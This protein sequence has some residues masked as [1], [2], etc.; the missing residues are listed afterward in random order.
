MPDSDT[1]KARDALLAKAAEAWRED[2]VL[3]NDDVSCFLDAYYQ[4]VAAEDLAPPSRLAAVA[5]AHAKL[6]YNRPQ[7]RALVQVREA[8][9]AYLDPLTSS[10][11]VVNIVTDDMPYLVDSVTTEL[12]RHQAEV[13]MI[14]HPLLR[15]R[16]DVTGALRAI[17]GVCGDDVD[18]AATGELVESWIH[19]ELAPSKDRIDPDQL[20][21]D[22]RHVLDDV[23]VANE[24]QQRMD[25]VARRLA[26]DLDA[27]GGP[28]AAEYGELL[29]WLADG[30]F[31]FLGYREYDLVPVEAGIG[32]RPVPG[33]GLG[34][35]RHRKPGQQSLN[36]LS[37]QIAA[38]AQDPAERLVLAKANSRSTVYRANYLDYVSVKRHDAAGKVT[39]ELRFL[40][41]YT[42]S[43]HT[44]PVASIPVLRGKLAYVLA[45]AGLTRDS[46][47]GKDLI[48]ILED[49]PREE[50]FEIS[51][52]ELTPIAFGV[53]RLSERKQTRLFLR[54]D[55]Y[56]RYMSCLVYLPR[57]RYTTKVRLRAQGILKAA[58]RGVT[59]DYS[60][61]V[62][63]S[64]L[65]RLH[66]V[67]RGE[68]GAP[69]P[70][71][72]AAALERRL[73][74]AVRSWDEDLVAEATRVLGEEQGRGLLETFAAAIPETYKADV[75]AT[76]AVED[77]TTMLKLRESG[78]EF[79]VRLVEGEERWTLVVYRL[80]TP[81]TL[82]DVLPQL[83]HMGLEVVDEH[84]YEFAGHSSTGS[85]WIY[86]FG[87]RPP[88]GLASV[89]VRPIFEDAVT[90]LW[91]GQT[92]DDGFNA[93]VLTAGLTWRE[94]TLLRAVAKYLR[95]GGMR[96]SED[97]VQRVLRSNAAIARLLVRLFES[98]FDPAKQDGAA[99]RCEAIAEEIRGMLD[100]VVS[101]DHDRILRAYL[102]M[103]DATLRTNYYKTSS[104][105]GVDGPPTLTLKL[106]PGNLPEL[107]S[108]RPKFEI[109]VYSPRLEAV[110]L[111]FGRV[112]R[113]GLRWSD[114]LEDFRTE[115][116]GLVKAQE[117]KNAVIVPSGAKG[118][119]VCKRLPDPG[120]REAYQAEVLACYKTFIASMLDVT[121]NIEGEAVIPPPEVVRR[122]GDDPYLVV[123]ADKGTATFSDTANEVAARY[124]FWLGDAFASG[125]SEGYDHKK[126]GI[127]ARGAWESVKVHFAALGLNPATDDFTMAG[128]GDMSGDVFGNG[129]LLSEHIK[130]VA[131][132]DHRHVFVDPDPDPAASF[133]ERQ[134][135]FDL[136]RSS[137]ADYDE[138]LISPGGGV[139]PRAVKS[140]PVSPQARTALGIEAGVTAL[141]PDALISAILAAPVDLLW[142]GGIGTYVKASHESHADVGDRSNDAVRVDATRLRCRVIG[143]GGNLGLTQAARIEYSLDGG[144]VNT[145]FIDNSAGVDTSDH[146]VNIKILLAD[147]IRAGEMPAAARHQLLNDMTD[148]VAS[149]VL[150]HNYGQN[151]ALAASRAQAP[152]LLHVHA[153]YLRKLVRDKRLDSELD[154]L[155]GER[156][157]A[158][159]RSAGTGLTTPEF[160]LLLAHTKIS[161]A[162]DVLA[163]GLPDDPYLRRVLEAYFPAPLRSA[164]ADR[165]QA[166]PLRREI[167]TT[168]VVNEMIDTS[169]TTFLFRLIEET[170]ASVPDLTRAWLVAREVFDMSAFWHQVEELEG[171]VGL[172]AQITLLLEGRK[173]TERA[174]RWLLHN[175]RPPFDLQAT[176]N[177]FADGV[178]TVRAGLPKLLTGRD[179]ATFEERRDSYLV[180]DVP[181]E[182]AERVAAMVPTYSAFDIVQVASVTG[183]SVEEA[184]EVYFDLADRLQ[185][186]RLRDRITALPREDR[187]S[188]MAR[189][190]LRDDLYAA[191][192]SLARDVLGASRSAIPR[193]PEEQLA[194]WAAQNESA[195]GMATQTLGE[196]WESERFTFTTLSVALRAIRTLVASSSL[197]QA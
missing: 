66:V 49:Y 93:L 142:N 144:L 92:E 193:N 102:A 28:D 86:E 134:R 26:D 146:E 43:A 140:V 163:S 111:R 15:D 81:I 75:T 116:L 170:G 103:I 84:P 196:I 158:E 18:P 74:A 169:G 89:T 195:V 159:R 71:V 59:V 197:P 129:V 135:M 166:H 22:L 1:D 172:A 156:E 56:G 109:F 83:Q 78:T 9:H 99:E 118:G 123:A 5:E 97:Y 112:A 50:L 87:L 90:A 101:L 147:A 79:A 54:R 82:S 40:G 128:V 77:L 137:W 67:I 139:W 108:P 105:G 126:M 70:Q 186:T 94:V 115:V 95:Q 164:F 11:L 127:T 149:L 155:P 148:D 42:H 130:L 145:D 191:L 32:L 120:D 173:L 188:T 183:R 114:R 20:A 55:R 10:G 176:V 63:D 73:A 60:A 6:G 161:A 165:M 65:A 68:K 8:G 33:S 157:I 106:D 131:A 25:E 174:V 14:V 117:V 16:R 119:F 132:F 194:A 35:L 58:L 76:Y 23:R 136:P 24:D 98:R 34:I 162:E 27:E 52:E 184:A 138:A 180:L 3:A 154:V 29:R 175:R 100:E 181:E 185:I 125:G 80:G 38:R 178:R 39:R 150:R 30:N 36:K 177:F 124:G 96:F 153:R 46:H 64:A 45:S 48:E 2:P 17:I 152:S 133:A 19:V 88:A 13:Q 160:A 37:S 189:A 91:Q 141:S 41:L 151:M 167:I 21:A 107:A 171:R 122:D 143:E 192:A 7:G 72:D 182:L 187:W 53:L 121:D 179:L 4:R 69:V 110:H 104:R 51:A 190:A 113:G 62:G 57:D 44:A 61:Q 47:D 168:A 31:L 85:F 12:N